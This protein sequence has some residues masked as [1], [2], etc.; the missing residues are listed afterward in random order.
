[1]T[2]H[3]YRKYP[4]LRAEIQALR[5]QDAGFGQMC[6]DY[7]EMCTWLAARS[8]AAGPSSE[9]VTHAREIIRDLENEITKKLKEKQ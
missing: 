4:N 2:D 3:V 8:A 7:E 9:D 6:D 5:N 1:M